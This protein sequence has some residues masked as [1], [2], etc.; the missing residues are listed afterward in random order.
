MVNVGNDKQIDALDL[1]VIVS[2][3][4]DQYDNGD[5]TSFDFVHELTQFWATNGLSISYEESYEMRNR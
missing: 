5:I 2:E 1:A 4:I 3:L